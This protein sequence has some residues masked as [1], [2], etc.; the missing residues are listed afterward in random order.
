MMQLWCGCGAVA[1][2][3]HAAAVR[4]R[5][6][7]KKY[8]RLRC[9]CGGKWCGCGADAGAIQEKLAA[10]V[11]LRILI[12]GCGAAAVV[13]YTAE[14]TSDAHTNIGGS[15]GPNGHNIQLWSFQ[16]QTRR[17]VH[18]KIFHEIASKFLVQISIGIDSRVIVQHADWYS[19][20]SYTYKCPNKIWVR[21][22]R[23]A[24]T[25]IFL[26]IQAKILALLSTKICCIVILQCV[27]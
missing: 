24:P 4:L 10:A 25:K 5:L 18:S 3:L 16:V 6:F 19:G 15:T 13:F 7:M 2:V 23:S 9:G 11:R 12:C 8:M 1:D 22:G 14:Q 21:T 20:V 27:Y 26:R 17:S